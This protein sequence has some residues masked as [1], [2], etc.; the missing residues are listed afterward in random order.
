[1]TARRRSNIAAMAARKL[2]SLKGV[3]KFLFAL[4]T[5]GKQ[6][7]ERWFSS[8]KKSKLLLDEVHKHIFELG[9][10]TPP[11]KPTGRSKYRQLVGHHFSEIARALD[12]MRDIEFY[13]GRFPY[14]KTA[15]AKHR[16]LQFHV[17][18]FL[19]EIYILQQRLLRFIVFIERSH[20]RDP[21]LPGIKAACG[22]LTS[23]VVESMKK[24]VAIRASHVHKWRLS[25][26]KIERLQ[27]I[28]L[29]TL[30][31]NKKVKKTFKAF[32]ETEYQKTRKQ[33][34]NWIADG[35][36]EAQMVVDAYFDEVFKLVFD[37]RGRT[38]YPS[39][40]KF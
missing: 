14:R 35:I 6:E 34:L 10:P 25:D 11:G 30:M 37:E 31:P 22:V 17:E 21:R 8:K 23:F 38:T 3:D 18:A 16:H 1:L 27:A 36:A 9:P 12:T 32:Y 24:G 19:H 5:E 2:S 13:I 39:R 4:A 7:M 15:I 26:T 29:Y 20:R 33:W 28:S 40:L